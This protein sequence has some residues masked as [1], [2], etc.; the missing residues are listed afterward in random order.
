M[1]KKLSEVSSR[2]HVREMILDEEQPHTLAEFVEESMA[3]SII[4]EGLPDGMSADEAALRFGGMNEVILRPLLG[5]NE[6]YFWGWFPECGMPVTTVGG[7]VLFT[8]FTDFI[9][10]GI[11]HRLR[12]EPAALR[13]LGCD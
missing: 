1:P 7:E 13:L 9:G 4:P 2:H 6:H 10:G 8:I 11:G 12:I 3:H 5:G